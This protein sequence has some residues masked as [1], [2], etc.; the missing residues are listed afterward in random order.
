MLKLVDSLVHLVLFIDNL[1]HPVFKLLDVLWLTLYDLALA[2]DSLLSLISLL[3]DAL[4][5]LL[6]SLLIVVLFLGEHLYDLVFFSQN[7]M[8]RVNFF[9]DAG[10]IT[11]LSTECCFF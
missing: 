8:Q 9:F 2:L 1:A 4:G 6:T 7:L 5:L 10:T 3:L 11:Q